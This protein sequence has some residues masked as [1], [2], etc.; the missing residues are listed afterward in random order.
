[1]VLSQADGPAALG[2]VKVVLC[3]IAFGRCIVISPGGMALVVQRLACLVDDSQLPQD[4]KRAS[5]TGVVVRPS[6]R[7]TDTQLTHQS[8]GVFVPSPV[9]FAGLRSRH[10]VMGSQPLILGVTCD[11]SE[12]VA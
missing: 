10:Q 8:R 9:L 12:S 3:P 2:V 11:P 1:M 5:K 7:L 4:I 6:E